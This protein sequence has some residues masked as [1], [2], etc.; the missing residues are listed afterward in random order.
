MKMRNLGLLPVPVF[1]TERVPS[2]AAG[3]AGQGAPSKGGVPW[4]APVILLRPECH[5]NEGILQHELEH[6]R[7]WW[8]SFFL[9]GGL[10]ILNLCAVRVAFGETFWQAAFLGLW[11]SWLAHPLLYRASR[12]YRR[13]SEIRAYR[14][15]LRYPDTRGVKMSLSAAAELLAGP[16]YRL[17]LQ[18]KEARSLLAEE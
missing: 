8:T 12:R 14:V 3:G 2:L 10:V 7:Q 13:W 1:Y 17:G 6:V 18:F 4:F 5:G 16:R 15:Q 9:T 11:F